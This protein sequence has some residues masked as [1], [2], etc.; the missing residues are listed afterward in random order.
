MIGK[1]TELTNALLKGLMPDT[2]SV[3]GTLMDFDAPPTCGIFDV[4][5]SETV[6]RHY[7]DGAY[8]YGVAVE[9]VAASF[10]FV[11]YI[12]HNPKNGGESLYIRGWY[13]GA[14]GAWRAHSGLMLS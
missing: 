10:G 2:L 3:R 4:I 14:W 6:D 13:R 1:T 11:I 8:K 9:A 7:P 5:P 12:P